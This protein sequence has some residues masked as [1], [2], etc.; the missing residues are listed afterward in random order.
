[1]AKA[2]A[3]WSTCDYSKGVP[4]WICQRIGLGAGRLI[5]TWDGV[6]REDPRKGLAAPFLCEKNVTAL[7]NLAL[8]FAKFLVF[9]QK[10]HAWLGHFGRRGWKSTAVVIM[11]SL[12]SRKVA[13]IWS[14]RPM[15]EAQLE[16]RQAFGSHCII[17]YIWWLWASILISVSLCFFILTVGKVTTTSMD[18]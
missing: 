1:M 7:R 9:F 13:N 15:K 4:N 10:A 6:W 8:E 18:C 2:S 5:E 17:C 14:W 16:R 11:Q 3:F 12:H